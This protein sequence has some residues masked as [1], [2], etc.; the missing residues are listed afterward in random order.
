MLRRRTYEIVE[1]AR[2]GD[3]ASAVFDIV[4]VTLILANILV[5]I[6]E[7]VEPIRAAVP[8]FF[9]WFEVGSVGVFTIEYLLRL[10]SCVEN[11]KYGSGVFGRVRHAMRPLSVIDFL[12]VAPFYL[13]F[14]GVDLRVFRAFRLV[15]IARIA[16]LGRYSKAIRLIGVV[17]V[18]KKEEMFTTIA[19]MLGLLLVASTLMYFVERDVQPDAFGNIPQ[20]MWWGVSMLTTVGY[21]DVYPITPLGK[22]LGAVIAIM[23]VGMFALPTGILGAGFVEELQNA[24]SEREGKCPHCGGDIAK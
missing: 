1:A 13:P 5:F 20:A 17:L 9:F 22:L 19:L 23:G 21:G 4:I 18:E 15:R 3:R 2:S 11:P 16:K 10:W 12:A 7:S 24:R 14:L 6:V 8:G